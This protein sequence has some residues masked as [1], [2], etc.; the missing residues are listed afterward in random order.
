MKK[1]SC[2]SLVICFVLLQLLSIPA[3]ATDT[4]TETVGET[5]TQPEETLPVID[6]AAAANVPDVAFGTASVTNG[7]RT[8]DGQISL[9]ASD[10]VLDTA[11]AAF[12]YEMNTGTV[13]YSYNPDTMLYPGALAKILTAIVA[14]ENSDLSEQVTV[15]TA[16]HSTLP[17]G[18]RNSALKNG[19]VLS[20]G[21]LLHC[22][23]MDLSNDAALAIAEHIAGNESN[24]VTLMNDKAKELGCTN[25]VFTSCHGVDQGGQYTTA[26]DMARII[27]YAVKNADFCEIFGATEYIVAATNRSEKRELT[28]LNYLLG[29]LNV[30]KYVDDR[31]TGGLATYTSSSGASLA[32]TAEDNGMSLII[33]VM[34]CKRV[35]TSSGKIDTYGNYEEVWDLLAYCFDDFR[36]CRLIQDGQSMSQFT[37]ANGENHVVGQTTTAM[38]AILPVNATYKNL[39]MKYNVTGGG[40]T[41]PVAQ[42]QEVSTLQVWYRNSCIA[43]T[44]LYAMSSVRSV[45]NLDLQIQGAT[46]DD[47]DMKIWSFLGIVFLIIFVPMVIYL[48]VNNVR[49]A[50]ARNRRR[51]RRRSRRRSRRNDGLG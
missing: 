7:C 29:Q 15:S 36:I 42:G 37:V 14:L 3:F 27:Q 45:D 32:C 44:K 16:N 31:V 47:S 35:Y 11:Q 49:R 41:A 9:G 19:E 18:A 12:V 2:L 5:E 25:T 51:R 17:L 20:V 4:E 10:L 30:T 34:G 40:L 38:D 23:I 48:V 43:E 21:D 46:R 1:I 13:I 24:F 26:R 39:I 6:D 28:T 8:L 22:M 33:V 50:I